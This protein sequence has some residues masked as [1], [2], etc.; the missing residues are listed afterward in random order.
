MDVKKWI[1]AA[2]VFAIIAQI[3]YFIGAI[4]DMPYY[5]MQDYFSVWSKVMMPAA[6]P[7]P[8]TFFAFSIAFN[9]IAGLIFAGVYERIKSL[10][11]GIQFGLALFLVST[12]PGMF[13]TYL[14]INLPAMLIAS[15]AVQGLVIFLLMGIAFE[16]IL[17]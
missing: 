9:F 3:V 15:W 13:S 12:V 5:L 10:L 7:P 8:M 14:T 1:L 6:G 17:K 11:K 2:I 16:K 4:I